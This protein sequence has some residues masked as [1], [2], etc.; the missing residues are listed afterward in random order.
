MNPDNFNGPYMGQPWLLPNPSRLSTIESANSQDSFASQVPL[1]YHL[2]VNHPGTGY[3]PSSSGTT[4][5]NQVWGHQGYPDQQHLAFNNSPINPVESYPVPQYGIQ[6]AQNAPVM[7]PTSYGG[8]DRFN[9]QPVAGAYT[10]NFNYQYRPDYPQ[11]QSS[12]GSAQYPSSTQGYL[13]SGQAYTHND[14]QNGYDASQ[15]VPQYQPAFG[16][17]GQS[18][19]H[20]QDRMLSP[21]DFDHLSM[22]NP[23][24][25]PAVYGYNGEDR[26][27]NPGKPLGRRNTHGGPRSTAGSNNSRAQNNNGNRQNNGG[28]P[29]KRYVS[30]GGDRSGQ[31]HDPRGSSY[32]EANPTNAVEQFK[33]PSGAAAPTIKPI[34]HGRSTLAQAAFESVSLNRQVEQTPTGKILTAQPTP[35]TARELGQ[36][37]PTPRLRSRRNESVAGAA[38]AFRSD[39][40]KEPP[41]PFWLGG[42]RPSITGS[43]DVSPGTV[44]KSK[45]L[46]ASSAQDPFVTGPTD[47]GTAKKI[48]VTGMSNRFDGETPSRAVIPLHIP[49]PQLVVGPSPHLAALCPGG[50]KPTIEVAFDVANMPFVELARTHPNNRFTGLVRISNVSSKHSST[51]AERN[52]ATIYRR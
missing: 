35:R 44:I 10:S 32:F 17:D 25:Y 22:E 48:S 13:H 21:L 18:L 52:L 6:P 49:R 11:T 27:Y 9:Q 30:A 38:T 39:V 29:P 33:T 19:I 24:T 46:G 23:A 15:I 12:F 3:A 16:P 5:M 34:G 37:T 41:P 45:V 50:Q 42:K 26:N 40:M 47:I 20:N 14:W 43:S 1:P 7:P 51:T 8:Y 31:Y 28:R 36:N 2:P 4:T